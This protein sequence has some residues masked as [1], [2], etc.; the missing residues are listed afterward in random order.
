MHA[1]QS[2]TAYFINEFPNY[3]S[4]YQA[5]TPACTITEFLLGGRLIPRWVMERNAHELVNRFRI[6]NEYG[7]IV[8]GISINVAA[9]HR[10]RHADNAV[11][12][13]WREAA[14]D[15]VIGMYVLI[16]WGLIFHHSVIFAAYEPANA[17][18]QCRPFSYTDW[19]LNLDNQ[20]LITNT[21]VPQLKE[22]TPGGGAYLNEADSNEPDWQHVFYGDKYAALARVKEKYDPEHLLY[23]LTS[24]GSE[25]WVQ[26]RDGRLCR[27]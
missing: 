2:P 4:S 19:N 6:I 18:D 23:A 25:Y 8:S 16:S 22:I 9:G 5:M 15:I 13:A 1:N 17:I 26:R 20:K 21:L 7:A 10:H 14:T 12:P 3:Y 24:V 27:S 11:N